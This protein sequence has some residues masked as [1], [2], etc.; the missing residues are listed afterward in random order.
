MA[1]RTAAVSDSLIEAICPL[2]PLQQGILF[3]CLR[4]PA[5]TRYFVQH[6]YELKG[7]LDDELFAS[8]WQDVVK[9]HSILRTGFV[10]RRV[11]EP[12]QVVLKHVGIAIESIDR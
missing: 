7:D 1:T 10:W 9:R 6:V 8:A 2:S 4:Q 11:N 12:M 5:S 3:E